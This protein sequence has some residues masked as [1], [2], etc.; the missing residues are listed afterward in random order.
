M[1]KTVSQSVTPAHMNL[2]EVSAGRSVDPNDLVQNCCMSYEIATDAK[3]L[4]MVLEL[5]K[6][7]MPSTVELLPRVQQL[8]VE[9][10]DP[11]GDVFARI[12]L[13]GL[14]YLGATIAGD[15]ASTDL[16]RLPTRW[17]YSD[18]RIEHL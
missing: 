8:T 9:L 17:A 16:M 7:L 4:S 14:L 5:T 3:S 15:Y 11:K 6:E 18:L 12:T 13:E 2:F 1:P 10:H